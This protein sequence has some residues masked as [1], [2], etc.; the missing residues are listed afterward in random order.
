MKIRENIGSRNIAHNTDSGNIY[1]TFLKISSSRCFLS[2]GTNTVY[3]AF[4]PTPKPAGNILVGIPSASKNSF[5]ISAVIRLFTVLNSTHILKTLNLFLAL[6]QIGLLDINIL[7]AAV[8]G[9]Y[10]RQTHCRFG[11][12]HRHNEY[13]KNLP[14]KQNHIRYK[15]ARE[16]NHGDI[17]CIEH[18]L[19]THKNYHGIPLRQSSIKPDGE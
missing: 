5:H 2:F 14:R 19:D 1:Y 9:D 11:S 16:S 13:G 18:K 8:N 4:S 6:H 10:Y 17:D 15:I 3:F 7:A 12:S